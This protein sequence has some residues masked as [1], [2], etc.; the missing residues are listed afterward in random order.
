[1]KS[2]TDGIS[3]SR[4]ELTALLAFASQE[5]TDKN[6]WGVHF[7]IAGEKVFARA[8]NGYACFELEGINDGANDG[9][10]MVARKFLVD[11]QKELESKQVLRLEFKGASLHEAAVLENDQE[12]GRWQSA[13]DVAISQVTFP[14]DGVK[15]PAAN[16]KIAHCSAISTPYLKLVMLA[17]K[18]VDIETAYFY[19]PKDAGG[20]F[21]FTV[22]HDG[23]TSG[24]GSIVPLPVEAGAS[25]D[26]DDEDEEAA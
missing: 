25:D 12:L 11:G 4:K 2:T 16:R 14:W 13:K 6:K 8:T 23:K 20:A 3:L 5:E 9:E 18:A 19:A 15:L 1:M 22:G 10:W 24:L 21:I 26:E 17:A 7:R